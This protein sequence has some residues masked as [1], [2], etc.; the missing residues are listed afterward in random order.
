M[1]L[2]QK[3]SKEGNIESKKTVYLCLFMY[4]Y[5]CLFIYVGLFLF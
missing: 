3:L 5:V 1:V 4:L 2:I